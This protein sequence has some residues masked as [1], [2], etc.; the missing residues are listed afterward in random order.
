MV[1]INTIRSF[2]ETY[3]YSPIYTVHDCFVSNYA[4]SEK[5][6]DIYKETMFKSLGNP[7]ELIN[8]FLFY[9]L[10]APNYPNYMYMS[11][12]YDDARLEFMIHNP[13]SPVYHCLCK[14]DPI[15]VEHLKIFMKKWIDV[16]IKTLGVTK[17]KRFEERANDVIE[18]YNNYVRSL[19]NRVIERVYGNTDFA[20]ELIDQRI[21][22][23]KRMSLFR[24]IC[25]S[26]SKQGKNYSL[27]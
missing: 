20:K 18:C 19:C 1:A 7:M 22:I 17:T 3:G 4:M 26:T 25:F 2:Y 5:M 9:N 13:I 10:I 27:T 11:S 8:M 12:N 6:A 24:H 15:P 23:K 21:A 14:S 16:K